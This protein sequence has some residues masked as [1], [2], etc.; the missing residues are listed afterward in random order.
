MKTKSIF[1]LIFLGSMVLNSCMKTNEPSR[2]NEPNPTVIKTEITNSPTAIVEPTKMADENPLYLNL[3][4]HQHQPL[5]YKDSNGVYTRPWVRVHATKDYYDMAAILKGYPN[6]HVTFNLTPVLL[7]QLND[8]YSNGAIDRYWEISL[9]PAN[10]LSID[11]KK[12]ILERF[13][14]ANWDHIIARFPRYKELLDQRGSSDSETID[15]ALNSF[16]DQ[17]Y[18]DL[19]IWFNLAW[20]DPD[21][22]Q[23]SPMKELVEK[24]RNF[25]EEDKTIL[26]LEVEKIISEIVPLHKEMQ[27]SGQ[28]EVIT[29]PYSHPILPLIIDTNLAK[30]GNPG[31]ETP[32]KFSYPQDALTHLIKST[33]IYEE[34]F[35]IE[36][37]G[38]WPGEGSVAQV[39]VPFVIKAGYQ[40]MASG[41]PV[42]AK[43][44]GIDSFTRDSKDT[45]KEADLLYRPYFVTNST[46]DKLAV[47]FRDGVISDKLGFTYSGVSGTAAAKDLMQRLEN[48]RTEL[49]DENA[50][51]P[52]IVSII[53]DGENAW[54]NYDNDGKEFF[55]AFYQLLSESTTIKTITPSKYIELY[56][57]QRMIDD[58]FAGAWF[59]PNYDTWIGEPEETM[60]W[61]Y[62]RKTR[63]VLAKYDVTKVRKTT[64]AKLSQAEDFMYLAEGS[65][66]FW[67]YGADQD[68]GQDQYF[69]EGYR[70]LLR[71]VF[72][73]LDEPVPSFVDTPIIQAKPVSPDSSPIGLSTPTIDGIKSKD[74]WENAGVYQGSGNLSSAN[75][76]FT[77][78]AKNLYFLIDQSNFSDIDKIDLYFKSPKINVG[79]PYIQ[80]ESED[81]ELLGNSM[82][83]LVQWNVISGISEFLASET[84]WI[85]TE[86]NA[87]GKNT[88]G[89]IEISIPLITFGELETGDLIQ[90]IILNEKHERI[91]AE[92]PGQIVIPD[93][94]LSTSLF[95]V[96]D[97]EGDDFGPGTFTYPTDSV[98]V[99]KAFDL[100]TFKV[101]YDDN[102]LIFKV[103]LYGPIPNSWNSP[104]NLSIQTIDIYIDF[105]PGLATGARK[106]LPGRNLSLSSSDGWEKAIWIEG[107]TP[108]ILAPDPSTKEPKQVTD[109]NYKLVV[110]SGGR[111]VTVRIP[112]SQFSQLDF[113]KWGFAVVI[114]GQEGYPAAGVWRVRDIEPQ[115]AQWR[116][117]GA[118]MDT[119]HTRVIDMIWPADMD[120]TQENMLSNYSPS[121]LTADQLNADDYG[122]I[123]LLIP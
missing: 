68:S 115:N 75:I 48:I 61:E 66:W 96:N 50:V 3:I 53:L 19:Q 103:D 82:T 87:V 76:L 51:G 104:N 36:P 13:F 57:D 4:W 106:L 116:F 62:L 31:A 65:D 63:E 117:G 46:G 33:T 69:D 56:P 93:L 24:E 73:S 25:S 83:N 27:E 28:I 99:G 114:L 110:D 18:L 47:F 92:G 90:F 122:I 107:W 105:D 44:L 55:H 60:A 119:N 123:N 121:N 41:E 97:P 101:S 79:Y 35:G 45:V 20:F 22:L 15:K 6:V 14:D 89:I 8:F 111:S 64:E 21:F 52:H 112:K 32:L 67:W 88:G 120:P 1:I 43:S 34:N 118:P 26:F 72:V 30:I 102:N 9:V 17:D 108:Q 42:L 37:K 71:N 29:T 38:L 23:K 78:D 49:T 39:M 11:Q 74:E 58:L 16:S 94:G 12:F 2:T 100:K 10:A 59:S 81:L 113:E 80:T 84:Q 98:F 85:P 5:Y 7:K 95:E 40:W 77:Q 109:A 54:E 70:A 91:P 86:I